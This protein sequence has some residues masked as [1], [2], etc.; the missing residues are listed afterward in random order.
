MGHRRVTQVERRADALAALDWAAQQPGAQGGRLAL[1]GWSHGGSAVLAATDATR[2][3]GTAAARLRLAVAFYPGC[4]T[5]LREGYRP[6]APL[7]LLLGEL[8]DWTPPGP[9]IELGRRTG[10]EVHVYAGSQHDFDNPVGR[11][12]LRTDVPNGRNPGQGVHSGPNPQAREQAYALL[13][14]RLNAAMAP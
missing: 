7:L 4:S 3:E 12:R 2:P 11:L 6:A 8:D 9:C 5:A 13:L 10:A 1:L 14:R